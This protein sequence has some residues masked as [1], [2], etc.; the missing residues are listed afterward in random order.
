MLSYK[1]LDNGNAVPPDANGDIQKPRLIVATSSKRSTDLV[2]H[3]ESQMYDIERA[4]TSKQLLN[5]ISRSHYHLIVIDKSSDDMDGTSLLRSLMSNDN[6]SL[7]VVVSETDDE[8]DK[9]VALELGA[10]DCVDST[11]APRELKARVSALLRRYQKFTLIT[12]NRSAPKTIVSGDELSHKNW[13]LNRS[14]CQL[15]SPTGESVCL[16]SAEFEIISVLFSEPGVVKDR[17]SLRNI[18]VN[19]EE[20]DARSLDVFVSRLRKKMSLYG[21]QDLIE[22]VRGRGYR[23]SESEA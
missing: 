8:I 22:T 18:A 6:Q 7:V 21:G 10:D 23:L 9:I 15:Y 20:Y 13:I 16:T 19:N 2:V 5:L 17:L 12:N 3:L 14:R 11:C 4:F 1:D